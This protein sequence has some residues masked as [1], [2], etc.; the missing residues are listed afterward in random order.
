MSSERGRASLPRQRHALHSITYYW[1]VRLFAVVLLLDAARV[2]GNQLFETQLAKAPL[3]AALHAGAFLL[4]ACFVWFRS[5]K[6]FATDIGLE[7]SSGR[8]VRLIPWERVIDLR[9]MPWMTLHPP[10]YPKL[11][12]LDLADGRSLDFIGRRDACTIVADL[13]SRR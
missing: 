1:L 2:V 3:N 8:S 7:L 6:V 5:K 13:A 9:E 11:Y 10:W 12:Q 4:V